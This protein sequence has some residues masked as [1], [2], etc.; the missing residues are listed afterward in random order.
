MAF[1]H[2]SI[3][4]IFQMPGLPHRHT[5]GRWSINTS[6]DVG[7]HGTHRAPGEGYTVGSL[8]SVSATLPSIRV[9]GTPGPIFSGDMMAGEADDVIS[10]DMPGKAAG[11]QQISAVSRLSTVVA[12][13]AAQVTS[14]PRAY[15]SAHL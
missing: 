14:V 6:T 9:L 13:V 11:S 8:N 10:W 3:Q 5:R 7:A 1:G 4:D 2:S 12:R 15:N